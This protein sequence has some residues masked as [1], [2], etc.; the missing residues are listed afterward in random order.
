MLHQCF[1]NGTGWN[2]Q[3][4]SFVLLDQILESLKATPFSCDT[5]VEDSLIWAYSKNGSFS[6]SSAYLLAR[7]LNPLNLDTI[8]MS[9]VW[10]IAAPPRV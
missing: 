4:S 5:N 8:A 10:K 7:G 3:N 2:L 9:W 6:L 1:D